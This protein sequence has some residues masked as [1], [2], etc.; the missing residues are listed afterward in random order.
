MIYNLQIAKSNIRRISG[1][2]KLDKREVLREVQIEP[3]H[4]K[5]KNNWYRIG[6]TIEYFKRRNDCRIV[7]ELLSKEVFRLFS[8]STADYEPVL[9]GKS[10]RL[11]LLSPNIQ[12]PDY[13][14]Y[15][16]STLHKLFPEMARRYGSYTLKNLLDTVKNRKIP[17]CQTLIEDII[18]VYVLDWFT[19]QLDR[20]PKNLL[21]ECSQDGTLSM[22]SLIDSESSFSVN[23]DGNIDTDSSVLWTPAIP[24]E[25]PQ[26]SLD[27]DSTADFDDNIMCLLMEYPDI[28]IPVLKQLTDT[29]FDSIISQYR[30]SMASKVYLADGGVDYLRSFVNAKQEISYKM[31]KT[32]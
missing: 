21:F 15:D 2:T 14:Y 27:E 11:G 10:A 7:G 24:Y 28:V 25:D 9:F 13:T 23:K 3:E 4:L 20:N 29:N 17:E 5:E 8:K 16:V 26:F 31:M 18:T 30:K 32:L 6:N 12:R 22:A 1:A 19:H